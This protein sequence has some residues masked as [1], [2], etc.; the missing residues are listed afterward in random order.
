[1]SQFYDFY[2]LLD[3]SGKIQNLHWS[4][5]ECRERHEASWQ[6]CVG[7]D[8]D[9][10]AGLQSSHGS[11]IL[12]WKGIDFRWKRED[13]GSHSLCFLKKRFDR[14]VYLEQALNLLNE[15]VQIYDENGNI[16]YFDAASKEMLDKG[17]GH[18]DRYLQRDN[19]GRPLSESGE[20]RGNI[21]V[22]YVKLGDCVLC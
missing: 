13:F 3:N 14:E 9:S 4:G 5:T 16:V 12:S 15:G 17:Q 11:G 8:W 19:A 10:L 20:E 1:M 18:P 7:R 21:V 2:L 22:K 6:S